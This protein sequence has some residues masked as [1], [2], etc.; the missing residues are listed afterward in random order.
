M[1]I[2]YFTQSTAA[3]RLFFAL[4]IMV[5]VFLIVLLIGTI[6]GIFIFDVNIFEAE[7]VFNDLSNPANLS[8]IKYFQI[9]NSLG[10]FVIPPFVIAAFYSKDIIQ[11]LSLKTYPNITELLLVIILIISAVPGINLLAEINNN[12]PLPDFME[13]VE[14]W[15]RASE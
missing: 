12:I 9:I 14:T 13:P 5:I 1:A 6:A 3:F 11:Y 10:L 15:M 7:N 4:F 2:N 8:I